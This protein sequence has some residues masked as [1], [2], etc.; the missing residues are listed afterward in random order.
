MKHS[1]KVALKL[2]SYTFIVF[3][4][5]IGTLSSCTKDVGNGSACAKCSTST[6]CQSGS[7]TVYSDKNGTYFRCSSGTNTSCP[8]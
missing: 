4:F 7:C 5:L 2:I 8:R 6:D 1:L 3:I